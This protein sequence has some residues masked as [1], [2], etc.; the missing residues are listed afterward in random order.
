MVLG[1]MFNF[2]FLEKIKRAIEEDIVVIL[3]EKLKL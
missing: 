2:D 1:T 3:K